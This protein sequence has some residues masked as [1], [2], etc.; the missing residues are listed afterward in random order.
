M[1]PVEWVV[2]EEDLLD[3]A[4]SLTPLMSHSPKAGAPP[5]PL[6]L[7]SMNAKELHNV[8]NDISKWVYDDKLGLTNASLLSQDSQLDDRSWVPEPSADRKSWDTFVLG[9]SDNLRFHARLCEFSTARRTFAV[10]PHSL[11][12]NKSLRTVFRDAPLHGVLDFSSEKY[13]R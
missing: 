13:Q 10:L 12:T 7:H 5:S 4:L 1:E 3:V 9:T 8:L 6:C 2:P 11:T